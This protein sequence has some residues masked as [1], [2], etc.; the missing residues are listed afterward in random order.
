MKKYFWIVAMCVSFSS[1][2]QNNKQYIRGV[3]IDKLSKMPLA[4][5]S[6]EIVVESNK[7]IF[8]SDSKGKYVLTNL[9]PASYELISCS[10]FS[11]GYGL[12]FQMQPINS[13]SS[14]YSILNNGARFQGVTTNNL[15]N[16]EAG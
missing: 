7:R 12:H 8:R 6:V 11:I 5:A 13:Y 14:S 10:C 9:L 16:N 4:S 3:V 15:V 2:S 1:F